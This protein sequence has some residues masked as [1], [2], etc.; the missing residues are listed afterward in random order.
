MSAPDTSS[1]IEKT[2]YIGGERVAILLPLPLGTT[3]DYLVPGGMILNRGDFVSVP[4]GR[5]VARGV[6]WDNGT[7]DVD[8][9]KLKAITARLNV[10]PLPPSSRAFIS[11]VA[12]YTLSAP[13]AILRMVMSVPEALDPPKPITAYAHTAG[14]DRVEYKST[15]ARERVLAV[16]KAGPP[17]ILK[18]LALE[19]GTG[20]GVVKGLVKA[21]VIDRVD[22]LPPSPPEPDHTRRGH[23]LSPDQ[24]RA[25]K[26]LCRAVDSGNFSVLVLDGVP[27]SGKTEVYFEAVARALSRGRQVLVM[28]PEIALGAQWRKRFVGRFGITPLEWHSDLTRTAKRETWRTVAKGGARVIVGARSGLFLPYPDLGLIVVDEEHDAAYKQEDGVIYNARDMAVVRAR[29]DTIPVVLVSATPSLETVV[30]AG[31]G[32]Y[33]TLHLP[34]RHAGVA[35]PGVGLID[36]RADK[37][38]NG[39]WISGTLR[40][41]L[42]DTFDRGEQAMLFLNRRGYAPLTL[43]RDCGHRLQCPQCSTWLVEHR[44]LGRLQCHHCGHTTR[45]PKICPGEDCGAEGR[46]AACGP[47]VERLAEELEALF[48]GIRYTVATSDTIHSPSVAEDLVRTIEKHNID[49]IVGTQI[50][51][52]GYHFPLLTLVGVVDADLGLAGGDLR[53]AER[54]YQLLYQVAGRAGREQRPGRVMLQ[55]HV[56][57]HPVMTALVSGD[58]DLFIETETSARKVTGM[59]PFGRL[60]ALI[61]SGRDEASVERAAAMLGRCAPHGDGIQVFGPAPAPISF[62]RGRHRR[63]LLLKA[64]KNTAVQSLLKRWISTAAIP[65]KVRVRIDIDPYSFM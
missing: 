65:K 30:N 6:V 52:K 11:W 9:E 29:I 10:D 49:V 45:L 31:E 64:H 20:T 56:P 1:S 36:M 37:L 38:P 54:T 62:L 55:T 41:A 57:D 25:A 32:R 27:G 61:V 19:A 24:R 18:E 51:A 16:L 5:T 33:E 8:P 63:R 2:Q 26:T 50:V 42:R 58:R 21:G 12:G 47:G 35:L 28:L 17:R 40:D 59:P 46:F 22:L 44:L 39:R 15:P 48:P 7:G 23:A 4:F 43:C 34:E 53:A 13:G 14:S 60:A 3:Y